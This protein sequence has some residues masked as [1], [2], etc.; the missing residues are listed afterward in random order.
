MCVSVCVLNLQTRAPMC[1]CLCVVGD[2]SSDNKL[3][4]ICFFM[5]RLRKAGCPSSSEEAENGSQMPSS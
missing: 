4:Q 5:P 2:F 1:V 3:K